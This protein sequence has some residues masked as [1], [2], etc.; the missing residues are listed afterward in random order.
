MAAAANS[1]VGTAT[2][3]DAQG[4]TLVDSFVRSLNIMD[5]DGLSFRIAGE[6]QAIARLVRG[7][8]SDTIRYGRD[9]LANG[10]QEP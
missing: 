3:P 6:T 10:G 5:L 9:L 4:Q 8:T 2:A 1:N 7:Q